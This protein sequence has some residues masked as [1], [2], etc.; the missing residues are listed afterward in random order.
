L[1]SFRRLLDVRNDVIQTF[2]PDRK[3]D[4]ISR[5]AGSNLLFSCQLLMS[6]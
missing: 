6:G 1:R 4:K 3:P 5:Y 2:D